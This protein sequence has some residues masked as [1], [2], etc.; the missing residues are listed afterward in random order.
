MHKKTFA[1]S[2]ILISLLCIGC[3]NA[4]DNDG[5]DYEIGDTQEITDNSD[6]QTSPEDNEL[7]SSNTVDDASANSTSNKTN[8]EAYLILDNDANLENIY[9][10]D[11]VDW[12]ISVENKGPD[13]AENVKV[14][15]ELPDGLEYVKHVT[16][17]GTFDPK[18]GI[19]N[20]GN[21]SVS[22]G[23][24]VLTITTKALTV[25]EKI[26]KATLTTDSINLNN[27]S[28]EEEEIDVFEHKSYQAKSSAQTLHP[29]GNPIPLILLSLLGIVISS[30]RKN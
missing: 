13:T 28:Y 23:E 8:S 29:T 4:Q 25:G 30:K 5:A 11:L 12:I 1:I 20:I 24:V 19:W 10:G 3:V 15:D 14:T 9:V 27:E 22:E 21:L 17:K 18:T 16:A 2:L 26:N 6:I 7:D